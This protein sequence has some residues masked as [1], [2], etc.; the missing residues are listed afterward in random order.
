MNVLWLLLAA[1]GAAAIILILN[2]DSGSFLG[3]ASNDFARFVFYAI[4]GVLVGAAILPRRGQWREAAR[5]AVGWIAIVLV[6]M[7]GY[8]YRY[9]LQDVG[10]RLTGGLIAGSPISAQA[11]QG[12]EQVTLL[13]ASDRHFTARG[14]AN[15]ALVRFVVD[16][17]ASVVVLTH[18]DAQ[19]AGIDTETLV[20]DLP[21]STA[22]GRTTAARVRLDSLAVGP[23]SRVGISAMVARQG[24]LEQSLLGMNFL[25]S[26]TSF[27]FRGDR[28]I[29]TD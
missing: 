18:A 28:L 14:E 12:R 16:T 25:S 11:V 15:G 21:V 6:L 9:E 26:L 24:A 8:L 20:Y 1:I 29:L 22:N 19:A 27:E 10:S 13:R 7:T 5:N 4:W 23:I 3:L 17:G 2:H